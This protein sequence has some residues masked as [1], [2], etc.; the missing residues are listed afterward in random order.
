MPNAYG[1]N[2]RNVPLPNSTGIKQGIQLGGRIKTKFGEG[3]IVNVQRPHLYPSSATDPLI[4]TVLLDNSRLPI[5]FVTSTFLWESDVGG[6]NTVQ[7]EHN[8]NF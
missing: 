2:A 5:Q 8:N 3:R 6:Q 4:L 1:N 7:A